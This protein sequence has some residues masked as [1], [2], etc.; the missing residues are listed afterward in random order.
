MGVFLWYRSEQMSVYPSRM[1]TVM[2][3]NN[4]RWPFREHVQFFSRLKFLTA[5]YIFL[6]IHAH[7][8]TSLSS[9]HVVQSR[10]FPSTITKL[11]QPISALSTIPIVSITMQIGP[12]FYSVASRFSSEV[13]SSAAFEHVVRIYL[14]HWY[15][16]YQKWLLLS[17]FEVT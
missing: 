1:C 12:L 11:R 6:T 17:D 14:I 4:P 13:L 7:I 5:A 8:T 9:V 10:A 16:L 2:S 3:Q 15:K